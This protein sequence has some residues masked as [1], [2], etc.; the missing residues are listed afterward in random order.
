MKKTFKAL[1]AIMLCLPLAFA[2]GCHKDDNDADPDFDNSNDLVRVT[3]FEP[4]QITMYSASCG[5]SVE[6]DESV[7]LYNSRYGICWSTEEKP[8]VRDRHVYTDDYHESFDLMLIDSLEPG[9]TYYVRAFVENMTFFYGR[10]YK[11]TTLTEWPTSTPSE[12]Y[13]NSEFSVSDTDKVRFS[14]GFLQYKASE[15]TWRFADNQWD[16]ISELQNNNAS[17]TYSEWIDCFTYGSSGWYGGRV[18]Y[19]P[20]TTEWHGNDNQGHGSHEYGPRGGRMDG[21]YVYSDWGYYNAISNGGNKVGQWRVLTTEEWDYLMNKRHTDSGVLF[22]NATVNG[23]EGRI[24]LPDNWNSSN[25]ALS[26]SNDAYTTCSQNIIT[27][28]A[29][30]NYFAPNGAVFCAGECMW[31]QWE[32][33]FGVAHPWVPGTVVINTSTGANRLHVR[34]VCDV[35]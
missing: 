7:S 33:G 22:A 6:A 3:T 4:S 8:T 13:I 17:A 19:Q 31:G 2:I 1:A 14:K 23:V 26:G 21:N 27:A 12:G 9:T 11:F 29:W 32:L 24:L 20:Y 16:Q 25:Y 15:D 18:F 35:R 34:L 5:G 28:D 30:S 10:Q